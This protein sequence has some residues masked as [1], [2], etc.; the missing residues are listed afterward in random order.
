[1]NVKQYS[2]PLMGLHS[3]Q[4]LKRQN[5]YLAAEGGSDFVKLSFRI[6]FVGPGSS[7]APTRRFGQFSPKTP[8]VNL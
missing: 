3:V 5:P 8:F 4:L 7:P 6:W 1:M 2:P